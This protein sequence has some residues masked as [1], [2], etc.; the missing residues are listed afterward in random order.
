MALNL[1][2]LLCDRLR[3]TSDH[4]EGLLFQSLES[5]LSNALL[6]RVAGRKSASVNITQAELGELTGVTRESREQEATR[7]AG[8]RAGVAAAGAGGGGARSGAAG[9]DEVKKAVPF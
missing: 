3:L 9:S 1:I 4:V 2:G 7:L 8:G 6:E 5:R